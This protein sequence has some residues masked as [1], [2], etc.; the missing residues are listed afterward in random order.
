MEIPVTSQHLGEKKNISFENDIF[1]IEKKDAYDSSR[2][3]WRVVENGKKIRDTWTGWSRRKK[4]ILFYC[5]LRT[6]SSTS[7][8]CCLFIPL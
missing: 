7:C 6:F 2:G 5:L 3:E 8:W 4:S 1:V